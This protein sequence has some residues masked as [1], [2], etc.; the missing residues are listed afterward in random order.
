MSFINPLTMAPWR[1]KMLALAVNVMCI[2]LYSLSLIYFFH[3]FFLYFN[4][5]YLIP[6]FYDTEP[7]VF[8]IGHYLDFEFNFKL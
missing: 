8:I 7:S 2:L 5:L 3:S 6:M 4:T 1:R